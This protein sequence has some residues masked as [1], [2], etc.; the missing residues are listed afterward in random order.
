MT[1]GGLSNEF[2][3][4]LNFHGS[5]FIPARYEKTQAPGYGMQA[6][7]TSNSASPLFCNI[8]VKVTDNSM[9]AWHVQ[10]AMC[11]RFSKYKTEHGKGN[12]AI[13]CNG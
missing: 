12:M 10:C 1:W 13:A 6:F 8:D 5:T 7:G 3:F 11:L 2:S 9:H 4:T